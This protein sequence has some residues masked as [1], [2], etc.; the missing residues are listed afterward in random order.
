MDFEKVLAEHIG[1]VKSIARRM[2]GDDDLEQIGMIALWEAAEKW[3]GSHPFR[4]W[5]ARVI[6]NRMIDY[7]RSQR[8]E[9]EELPDEVPDTCYEEED[10]ETTAELR[11]RIRSVFPRR[12]R[13][14]RVLLSLTAGKSKEAIAKKLNVSARTV[15]RIAKRAYMELE[16]KR[17][18]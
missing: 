18:D 9:D 6:R 4:P 3:N 15:D 16:E 7:L 1:L 14:C 10:A 11:Q 8:P 2:H 5:A 17:R 13:E 12:S